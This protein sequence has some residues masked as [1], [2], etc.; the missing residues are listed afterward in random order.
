MR[1]FCFPPPLAVYPT[2]C[3]AK[4]RGTNAAMSVAR[5]PA[6]PPATSCRA[7]SPASPCR[8]TPSTAASRGERFCPINEAITRIILKGGNMMEIAAA[9]KASGVRDLRASALLKVRQRVTSLAEI[10]RVT[11]D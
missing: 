5:I 8:C 1:S 11:K 7:R 3:L 10:N 2:V 4:A 6:A 9:A